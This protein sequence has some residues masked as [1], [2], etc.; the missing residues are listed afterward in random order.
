MPPKAKPTFYL[1]E[2]F[3]S[4]LEVQAAVFFDNHP[5]IVA[6]NY[7]PGTFIYNGEKYDP[8][9]LVEINRSDFLVEVKPS[10]PTQTYLDKLKV[11]A[12]FTKETGILI[13]I[14]SWFKE[15]LPSVRSSSDGFRTLVPLQRSPLGGRIKPAIECVKNIRFDLKH[16]IK[17]P[18]QLGDDHFSKIR[19]QWSLYS[20]KAR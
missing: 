9:F 5:L 10:E 16:V 20:R 17:S 14:G 12:E 13:L 8:D 15:S 19:Q 7:H 18:L 3:D 6:R 4:Q 2:K 1:E 11:V